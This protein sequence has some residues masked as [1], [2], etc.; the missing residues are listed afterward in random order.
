MKSSSVLSFTSLLPFA[1]LVGCSGSATSPTPGEQVSSYVER[2]SP[3]KYAGRRDLYV[4]EYGVGKIIILKNH[5]YAP[6][7]TI[8]SG[9]NGPQ[10]VTLDQSGNLYVANRNGGNVA[11]YAPGVSTPAFVYASAIVSPLSVSVDRQ[12]HVFVADVPGFHAS[13]A[14]VEYQQDTNVP[15]YRA[16]SPEYLVSQAIRPATYSSTITSR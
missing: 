4:A 8:T 2:S 1:V 6:D 14:I 16:S 13:D 11:E 12:G 5:G 9:I 3:A 7:G 15:L 10:G